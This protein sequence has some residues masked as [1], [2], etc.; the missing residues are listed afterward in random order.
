MGDVLLKIGGNYSWED[1]SSGY[2]SK[3][4]NFIEDNGFIDSSEAK[5]VAAAYLTKKSLRF[6]TAKAE[7]EGN[8][9]IKPGKR[10]TL[11]YVGEVFSGEYLTES[12]VHTYDIFSGYKTE[13]SLVRNYCETTIKQK[14]SEIDREMAESRAAAKG[15][16]N[17]PEVESNLYTG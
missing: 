12:V 14:V 16:K 11:K 2:D 5:E 3:R 15:F 9:R 10:L 7:T 4:T 13:C 6:Q 17:P 1:N 8:C